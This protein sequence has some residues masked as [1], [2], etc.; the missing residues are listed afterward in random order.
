MKLSELNKIN[1]KV[2]AQPQKD[3]ARG[4]KVTDFPAVTD[5]HYEEKTIQPENEQEQAKKIKVW[6]FNLYGK[7]QPL[8][9][10]KEIE[11]DVQCLTVTGIDNATA[12]PEN[13]WSL[14]ALAVQ[15]GNGLVMVTPRVVFFQEVK[16]AEQERTTEESEQVLKEYEKIVTCYDTDITP[17]TE[18]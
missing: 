5:I 7:W 4:F 11:S 3:T 2:L 15:E 18:K 8:D 14:V 9:N 13:S 10:S 12:N 16:K 17:I 6:S 1:I